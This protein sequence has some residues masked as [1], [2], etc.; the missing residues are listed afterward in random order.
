MRKL[1]ET[2]FVTLDGAISDTT[3]STA[4]HAAPERGGTILG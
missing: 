4:P 1:V 2:T 3:P